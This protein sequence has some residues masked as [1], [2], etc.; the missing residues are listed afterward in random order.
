MMG[1]GSV[2]AHRRDH[3]GARAAPES[4]RR[5]GA[6]ALPALWVLV[7]LAGG[8]ASAAYAPAQER[9]AAAPADASQG[10]KTSERPA[11][12]LHDSARPDPLRRERRKPDSSTGGSRPSKVESSFGTSDREPVAGESKRGA[13]ANPWRAGSRRSDVMLTRLAVPEDLFTRS[14]SSSVARPLSVAVLVVDSELV[15]A[16]PARGLA[17]LLG[18]SGQ[19]GAARA[20]PLKPGT[21]ALDKVIAAVRDE[22]LR[23]LA[24]CV[25]ERDGARR[26]VLIEAVGGRVVVRVD[27]DGVRAAPG[28]PVKAAEVLARHWGVRGS[29]RGRGG[30]PAGPDGRE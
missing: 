22:G 30:T 14:P 3:R 9:K 4:T 6:R 18:R 28:G 15:A 26:L 10:V 16:R 25:A 7:G 24:L 13:I 21:H 5:P 29:R 20:W 12:G 23:A 17:H 11:K 27:V 8:C 1:S 19:V 2:G